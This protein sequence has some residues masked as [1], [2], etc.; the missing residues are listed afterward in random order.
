MLKMVVFPLDCLVPRETI[1]KMSFVVSY[2]TVSNSTSE[3]P[4]FY[5]QL[6]NLSALLLIT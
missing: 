1:R 6:I 3:L 4:P 5:V 2:E